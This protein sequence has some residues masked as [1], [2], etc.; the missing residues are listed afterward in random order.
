MSKIQVIKKLFIFLLLVT[1]FSCKKEDSSVSLIILKNN[2]GIVNYES[3]KQP[4]GEKIVLEATPDPGYAFVGWHG[5]GLDNPTDENPLT[6]VL[7]SEKSIVANFVNIEN[8]DFS[9]IGLWTDELYSKIN[10]DIENNFKDF[11]EIFVKDAERHGLD[12]SYVLDGSL[13]FE[14]KPDLNS[15]GL[16]TRICIDDAVKIS[17]S[18]L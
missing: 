16:A 7:D 9:G 2:N 8:P 4:I 12:L 6:I 14:I 15:A 13:E 10:Y 11:V 5:E 18:G 1:I 3:G 17:S